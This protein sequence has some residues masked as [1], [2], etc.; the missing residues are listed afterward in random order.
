MPRSSF[1][2]TSRERDIEARSEKTTETQTQ[3]LHSTRRHITRPV[4]DPPLY[5]PPSFHA[6][7]PLHLTPLPPT[8][9]F[10]LSAGL[11]FSYLHICTCLDFSPRL[12]Y[13]YCPPSPSPLMD[14][15]EDDGKQ[16]RCSSAPR[17]A[18]SLFSRLTHHPIL[19]H[20]PWPSPRIRRLIRPQITLVP[21]GT[22]VCPILSSPLVAP[23]TCR[24]PPFS[25]PIPSPKQ[26]KK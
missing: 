22:T 14:E 6:H 25:V 24:K 21:V 1:Y 8:H 9:L 7:H 11:V 16:S 4:I 23:P 12:S 5:V 2:V 19:S 20:H 26:K 17:L 18:P 13:L 15:G 10:P 3:V